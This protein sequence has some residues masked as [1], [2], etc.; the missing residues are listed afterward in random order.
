MNEPSLC[1]MPD[2]SLC[3][4]PAPSNLASAFSNPRNRFVFFVFFFLFGMGAIHNLER[5][6]VPVHERF[7]RLLIYFLFWEQNGEIRR[8]INELSIG[9]GWCQA[10][11][12][13]RL[14][15]SR[16][17]TTIPCMALHLMKP[18]RRSIMYL[19]MRLLEVL[20]EEKNKR[21]MSKCL[22]ISLFALITFE[23]DKT[24]LQI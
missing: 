20:R 23:K 6:D 10:I 9:L 8:S 2:D 5:C 16:N 1:H 14:Y 4:G 15:S 21:R 11:S 12:A 3:V 24:R 17:F 19:N 7:A 13:R 22:K 18:R